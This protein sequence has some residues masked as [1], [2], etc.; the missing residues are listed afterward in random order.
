[1]P[2]AEWCGARLRPVDLVHP[3][4][5]RRA[6][7]AGN[8]ADETKLFPGLLDGFAPASNSGL[9]VHPLLGELRLL[10]GHDLAGLGSAEILLREPTNGALAGSVPDLPGLADFHR[11]LGLAWLT[12]DPAAGAALGG[13][14]AAAA[15]GGSSPAAGGFGG[16]C[17]AGT[18]ATAAAGGAG[19]AASDHF[20]KEVFKKGSVQSWL[21]LHNIF[22]AIIITLT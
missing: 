9:A 3:F 5:E 10:S 8:E 1:M 22:S 20:G 16:G 6:L 2:K 4:V 18:S 19:S 7:L 17:L 12:R 21:D 11:L 13:T 14:A 15:P